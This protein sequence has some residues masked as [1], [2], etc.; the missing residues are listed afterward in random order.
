MLSLQLNPFPTWEMSNHNI[1][2]I[3]RHSRSLKVSV[4]FL[5]LPPKMKNLRFEVFSYKR[6]PLLL[7]LS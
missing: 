2:A 3:C 7:L 1:T 4:K 6:S 5:F